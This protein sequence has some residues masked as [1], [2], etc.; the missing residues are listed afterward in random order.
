MINMLCNLPKF[1]AFETKDPFVA[2]QE[3]EESSMTDWDRFA[4]SEYYRLSVEDDSQQQN[5]NESDNTNAAMQCADDDMSDRNE[6]DTD[7][8]G[9]DD[10]PGSPQ[11]SAE[12]AHACHVFMG[13]LDDS[14]IIMGLAPEGLSPRA[15]DSSV[16][17]TNS[18]SADSSSS[19]SSSSCFSDKGGTEAV[20]S[21][22]KE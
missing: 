22:Q 21:L 9:L 11:L 15:G 7:M 10:E 14:N 12:A 17:G 4:L 5:M 18:A 16:S 20:S 2:R 13:G 8:R 1:M 3:R 19:S 6:G